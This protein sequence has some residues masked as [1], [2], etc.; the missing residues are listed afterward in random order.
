MKALSSKKSNV[1][2]CRGRRPNRSG[3]TLTELIVTIGI[4]AILLGISVPAMQMIRQTARR[5]HCTSNLRQVMVAALAYEANGTGFPPADDGQGGSF[6]VRLLPHMEETMLHDR[7]Q[8]PLDVAISETYGERLQ[9]LS[10]E[11]VELLICPAAFQQDKFAALPMQGEFT[12]HYYGVAGPIG[13][14]TSS[15]ATQTYT[16]RQLMPVSTAGPIGLNGL[17]SPKPGGK[18]GSRSMADVADGTS[19]SFALGE[20]SGYDKD[21]PTADS[22]RSGWAFGAGYDSGGKVRELYAVKSISQRINELGSQL[23]TL[24]FGSNHPGGTHFAFADGSIHFVDDDTSLDIL[25]TYASIDKGEKDE[26]L[27]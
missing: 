20:I 3:F 19:N 7:M 4:I 15:D 5:A 17:F 6:L 24:P 12:T 23:N 16:F 27:E 2:S 8:M 26:V 9:E 13:N 1:F 11:Q 10:N 25:K 21:Q 18:F 14:A 22:M